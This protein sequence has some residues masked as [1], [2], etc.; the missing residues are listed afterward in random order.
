L[1]YGGYIKYFASNDTRAH[2]RTKTFKPNQRKLSDPFP[3]VKD[4][5]LSIPGFSYLKTSLFYEQKKSQF[6]DYS[7]TGID[8]AL[9]YKILHVKNFF[10][11]H[12]KGGLT[13]SIDQ[14]TSPIE[15]LTVQ[16]TI[17]RNNYA[18]FKWGVIGGV[19]SDWQLTPRLWIIAGIDQRYLPDASENW[20]HT[21]WQAYGGIRYKIN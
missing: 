3:C 16:Q 13:A 11:L 14:L 12:L 8:V 17:K 9:Y 4:R 18:R 5:G 7:I 19:E 21:R 10:R 1:I 15:Q 6:I 20:G 2:R